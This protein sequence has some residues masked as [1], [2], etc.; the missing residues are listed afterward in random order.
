MLPL[1]VKLIVSLNSAYC[2]DKQLQWIKERTISC[3][4]VRFIDISEPDVPL[5]NLDLQW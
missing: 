2:K 4:H 1:M 5:G 3:Y